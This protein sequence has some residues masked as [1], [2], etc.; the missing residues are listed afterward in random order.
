MFLASSC[1]VWPVSTQAS[2]SGP[3]FFLWHNHLEA[4]QNAQRCSLLSLCPYSP[5]Q[6]ALAAL[7]SQAM[8]LLVLLSP[9]CS[10]PLMTALILAPCLREGD[11]SIDIYKHTPTHKLSLPLTPAT[12]FGR[13]VLPVCFYRGHRASSPRPLRLLL[14]GRHRNS[15]IMRKKCQNLRFLP[16]DKANSGTQP[17]EATVKVSL[18]KVILLVV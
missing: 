3:I 11:A 14:R 17:N 6:S 1:F 10:F 2:H 4:L 5:P 16:S 12:T 9:I 7:R 13:T 8:G 18:V 15:N